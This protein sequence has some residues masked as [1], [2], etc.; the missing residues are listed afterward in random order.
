MNLRPAGQGRIH[1]CLSLLVLALLALWGATQPW[2]GVAASVFGWRM[3]ALQATG[4]VAMGLMSV[5]MVLA[6]R[7]PAVEPWLGGLDKMYRLH[8]WLGIGALGLAIAHWLWVELPKWLVQ[9]G[10]LVRPPRAVGLTPAEPPSPIAALLHEWR[11]PAEAVGEWAFYALVLLLVLALWPRFPYRRFFQTHRLLPVVYLL[12]VFHAVVLLDPRSWQQPLGWVLAGLMVA[13]SL[14]ALRALLG[15]VGQSRQVL[16]QVKAVELLAH[17]EVLQV[18]VQLQGRWD[19]HAAGQFAF[20]RFDAAEGAHPFTITSPW[21]GDGRL[22]FHIKALGDYTRRLPNLLQPGDPVRVEGPYG[23][24]TF[25]GDCPRQVWVGA[26]I[27]ITP[28]MARLQVLANEPDGKRIDLFH[29]TP[30][31]NAVLAA[32]LRAAARAVT[33]NGHVALHLMADSVDGLLTADRLCAAVPDWR[34]ADIWFCGPAAFGRSL[35][36]GLLAK[37]L[38]ANHFHQELF[39]LR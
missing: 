3:P 10:V 33:H 4:L 21:V 9:A 25:E 22:L 26:G 14:A 16:G 6:N 39:N 29:T 17:T 37:G 23:Q 24:F 32:R 18:A 35:R 11:G 34:H 7:P 36:S 30:K 8:K 5:A 12:L 28:F 38:P 20:L 13:G 31:P 19:G 15:L 2:V 1:A 27:G